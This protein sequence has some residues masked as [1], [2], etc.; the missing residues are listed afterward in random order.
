MMSFGA[1]VASPKPASKHSEFGN[2][3]LGSDYIA[4]LSCAPGVTHNIDDLQYVPSADTLFW[5]F[6]GG[7]PVIDGAG[8]FSGPIVGLPAAG[9]VTIAIVTI[10]EESMTEGRGLPVTRS[11]DTSMLATPNFFR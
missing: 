3:C 9:V 7:D 10:S 11:L 4:E 1:I 2:T 5:G 6:T 8:C